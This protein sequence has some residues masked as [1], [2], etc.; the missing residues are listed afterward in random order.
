[1]PIAIPDYKVLKMIRD[2]YA[3]KAEL[4]D[5]DKAEAQ[6]L[7]D[8]G[9]KSQELDNRRV[10]LNRE[11][12]ENNALLM[13]EAPQELLE[14][15]L[16]ATASPFTSV[17][18]YYEQGLGKE[19]PWDMKMYILPTSDKWKAQVKACQEVRIKGNMARLGETITA[20]ETS[21]EAGDAKITQNHIRANRNGG[22]TATIVAK[23]NQEDNPDKIDF[24]AEATALGL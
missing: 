6:K 14:D 13:S 24:V 20:I 11:T 23:I 5:A 4:S 19:C 12:A 22:H 16:K 8:A 7:I 17:K 2:Q 21:V 1:M 18:R 10:E 9:V 3:D 15:V